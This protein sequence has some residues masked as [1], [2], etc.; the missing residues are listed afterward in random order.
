MTNASR[1]VNLACERSVRPVS[2]V[3]VSDVSFGIALMPVSSVP[4]L[5]LC[6]TRAST[7]GRA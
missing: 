3:M 2:H 6:D 7:S 5:K 4:L 1:S